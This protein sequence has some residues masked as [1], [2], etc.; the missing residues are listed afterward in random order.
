MIDLF[1]LAHL[2]DHVHSHPRRILESFT[3]KDHSAEA[4]SQAYI[5]AFLAFLC[6]VLKGEADLLHLWFGR[7]VATRIRSELQ[8]SIYAKALVRKD[9]S[10]IVDNNDTKPDDHRGSG[11][12]SPQLA[13]GSSDTPVP[14]DGQSSRK[15]SKNKTEDGNTSG[16]DVGKIV[17]LMSGDANRMS[18]MATG[19]YMLYVSSAPSSPG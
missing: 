2:C 13:S 14:M 11:T 6:T 18:H 7:R 12:G 19:M 9:Y 5:Y 8:A 3:V 15:A 10:G 1:G 17:N 4:R 16:A